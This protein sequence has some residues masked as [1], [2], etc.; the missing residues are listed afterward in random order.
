VARWRSVS[1]R[2]TRRASSRPWP[3]EDAKAALATL[4]FHQKKA[5]TRVKQ[6]SAVDWGELSGSADIDLKAVGRHGTVQYCHQ[7]SV[8]GG[9][10]TLI[11]GAY[12]NWSQILTLPVH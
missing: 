8:N 4:G 3:P 11:K 6:A 2:A 9:T 1:G 12:G 10:S 7:F 5:G